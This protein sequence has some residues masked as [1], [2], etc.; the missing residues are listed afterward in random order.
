MSVEKQ[1]CQ[2]WYL[3][4]VSMPVLYHLIHLS[5]FYSI[6]IIFVAFLHGEKSLL[7]LQSF[8]KLC[9]FFIISSWVYD[10]DL[11]TVLTK[12]ITCGFSRAQHIGIFCFQYFDSG[13]DV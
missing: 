8:L 4:S 7:S 12:E 6:A 5:D 2:I 10:T 13:A 9:L 3:M 1:K 11:I